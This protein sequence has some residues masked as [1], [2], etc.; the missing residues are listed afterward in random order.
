MVEFEA[1]RCKDS[2]SH[3]WELFYHMEVYFLGEV[4]NLC[5]SLC[6]FEICLVH[7]LVC[8]S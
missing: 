6:S 4:A 3:L 2:K 1:L 8:L 5:V 7:L